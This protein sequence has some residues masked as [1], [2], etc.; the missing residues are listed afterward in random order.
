M[1]WPSITNI[2]DDAQE[3]L[4]QTFSSVLRPFLVLL[5]SSVFVPQKVI[6]LSRN[7]PSQEPRR[8]QKASVFG[9]SRVVG[10]FE[11]QKILA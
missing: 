10:S 3:K 6:S 1:F 2:A 7:L 4:I 9:L 8:P 5:G 11:S